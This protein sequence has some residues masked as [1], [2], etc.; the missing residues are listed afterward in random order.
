MRTGIQCCVTETRARPAEEL[1][2]E[3]GMLREGVI[4]HQARDGNAGMGRA[5]SELALQSAAGFESE[6]IL[7]HSSCCRPQLS[8]L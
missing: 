7:K 4:K 5:T 2:G 8:H 6:S 3:G 1:H